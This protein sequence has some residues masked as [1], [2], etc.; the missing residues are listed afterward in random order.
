MREQLIDAIRKKDTQKAM[1]LIEQMTP[2]ELYYIDD[3]IFSSG[4]TA[5]MYAVRSGNEK[6]C[7]MLLE[8]MS[9]DAINVDNLDGNTALMYA[10]VEGKMD[11]AL[12]LIGFGAKIDADSVREIQK[13]L[14]KNLPNMSIE[15][16]KT[17]HSYKDMKELKELYTNENY[18]KPYE[19]YLKTIL[20]NQIL[21]DVFKDFY[22]NHYEQSVPLTVLL[23]VLKKYQKTTSNE[24]EILKIQ[25]WPLVDILQKLVECNGIIDDL[26]NN[27]GDQ[28]SIKCLND[29]SQMYQGIEELMVKHPELEKLGIK[30]LNLYFERSEPVEQVIIGEINHDSDLM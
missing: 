10:S 22:H 3:Y 29:I 7:E 6:I 19:N 30:C 18:L 12:K 28:D 1:S 23:G 27:Q 14:A 17:L 15:K 24:Q 25:H 2:E 9:L 11:I 13:T 5:L 8:K 20:G 16:L 4:Y 26:Q 21:G